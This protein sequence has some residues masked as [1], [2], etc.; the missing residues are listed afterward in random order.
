DPAMLPGWGPVIADIA[1]RVALDRTSNPSWQFAVT[2]QDGR[3]LHDGYTRRRPTAPDLRHTR[4]RDRTC[5]AVGCRHPATACQADHR[6][7][8]SRGGPTPPD[9]LDVLCGHHNRLK[10]AKNLTLRHLGNGAYEW[11]APNGRRY[12][13]PA[14]HTALL[15]VDEPDP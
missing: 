2:D 10:H 4:L 14:D 5:R 11:R 3:L 1:R 9:N 13:V 12:T 7:P 8:W 6:H 15:T